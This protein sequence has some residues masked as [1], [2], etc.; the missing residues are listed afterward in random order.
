MNEIKNESAERIL[1]LIRLCH[2]NEKGEK[3]CR[4]EVIKEIRIRGKKLLEDLNW[5]TENEAIYKNRYT[6]SEETLHNLLMKWL[7]PA[8][9]QTEFD[10]LFSVLEHYYPLALW[11]D[12]D[13]FSE[14]NPKNKLNGWLKFQKGS[15]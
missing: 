5:A 6:A 9:Q 12:K 13:V 15:N 8:L 1:H 3:Y 10:N 7:S 2:P 11:T 14:Y 4:S